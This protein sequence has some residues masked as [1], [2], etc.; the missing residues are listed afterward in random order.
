MYAQ[1]LFIAISLKFTLYIYTLFKA[2][3][4][5]TNWKFY[6]SS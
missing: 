2:E 6:K 5:H 3:M 4:L 1:L